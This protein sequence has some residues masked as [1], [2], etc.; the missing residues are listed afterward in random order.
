MRD[1]LILK[2]HNE[3]LTTIVVIAN[4]TETIWS[5]MNAEERNV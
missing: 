4:G 5:T 2:E 1:S 3:E